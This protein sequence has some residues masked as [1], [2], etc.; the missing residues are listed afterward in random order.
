MNQ[1]PIFV[2]AGKGPVAAMLTV[3][4]AEPRGLVVS[5][6]GTG[7]VNVIGST[8]CAH[9]SRR[10]AERGLAS[11]RLDYSGVGDSPGHVSSW[12][13]SD[14][15]E[16]VCQARAVLAES[17]EILGVTR[18]AVVGTCYGTRVALSLVPDRQCVGAVCLAL[19]ILDYGGFSRVT[20]KVGQRKA[21]SALR[22]NPLV[23]RLTNPLRSSVRARRPAAPVVA[24]F[25]CLERSRITFLYGQDPW[26]DHYDRQVQDVLDRLLAA[27][28]PERRGRFELRMLPWGPLTT[29]DILSPADKEAVLEVVVPLVCATFEEVGCLPA[30]V[31]AA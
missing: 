17:M 30:A 18:F 15:G 25:D 4:E 10:V 27:L 5:L 2:D 8:L 11:V 16:A 20:R 6:A 14:V 19:P 26:E 1:F 23:R 7:R 24:A 21:F 13:P 22:S 29:F 28:P 9:L 12:T 31:G 3:P